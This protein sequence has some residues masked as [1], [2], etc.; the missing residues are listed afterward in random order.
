MLIAHG[1]EK[2]GV[3]GDPSLPTCITI[4]LS[5][6]VHRPGVSPTEPTEPNYES[7]T[8][9]IP[10]PEACSAWALLEA[11]GSF[12]VHEGDQVA[13][14]L[15]WDCTNTVWETASSCSKLYFG[16]LR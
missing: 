13:F 11:G 2:T 12:E 3:R 6:F 1:D 15:W 8:D 4:G 5:V 9:C 10:L 16:G 14:E 7:S